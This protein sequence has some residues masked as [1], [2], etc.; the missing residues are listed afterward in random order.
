[1]LTSNSLIM[2][3]ATEI[4]EGV[5]T[6]TR[7]LVSISE[8]VVYNEFSKTL[9]DKEE[10][11]K[12][13]KA[14]NPYGDGNACKRIGDTSILGEGTIIMTAS[15]KDECSLEAGGHGIFTNLLIEA[16]NGGATDIL[17]NVTPG[18]I[19]AFIDQAL[20][21]WNQRPLFKANI[22]SFI[23]LKKNEPKVE[24]NTL[25]E[26]IQLF[27]TE[28]YFYSLDPSFEKTNIKGGEHRNCEPYAIKENVDKMSKLQLCNRN[29][30]VVPYKSTDMYFAAMDFKGCV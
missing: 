6:G 3:D 10:Y 20:G 18:S 9:D 15:R 12:M 19:Y 8:E 14:V 23:S 22:S 13:A 16:L 21:P 2:R 29:G 25:K 24:I 4:P 17:G 1:M 30:L 27:E 7:K 28:D 11:A 26:V 5:D